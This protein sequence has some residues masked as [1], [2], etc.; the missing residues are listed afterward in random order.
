[1]SIVISVLSFRLNQQHD[2]VEQDNSIGKLFA[3]FF[4][5]GFL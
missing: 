1:V 2:V 4:P 3:F 5:S